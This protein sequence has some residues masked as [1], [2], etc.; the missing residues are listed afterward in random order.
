MQTDIK[1]IS[2]HGCLLDQDKNFNLLPGER[3]MIL[4]HLIFLNYRNEH[5]LNKNSDNYSI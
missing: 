1:P 5:L 2:S 3:I 4:K